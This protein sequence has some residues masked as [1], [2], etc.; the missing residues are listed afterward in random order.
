MSV[1]WYDISHNLL[2]SNTCCQTWTKTINAQK[3]I[4]NL[5]VFI[6]VYAFERIFI[7]T[8]H[9][10]NSNLKNLFKD[11]DT[12]LNQNLYLIKLQ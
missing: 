11:L 9:V 4:S 3:F 5:H 2:L 8:L 1:L 12:H 7:P 10:L 6:K